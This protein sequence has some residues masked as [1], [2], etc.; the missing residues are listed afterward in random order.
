MSNMKDKIT[1]YQDPCYL[2]FSI[3]DFDV[4]SVLFDKLLIFSQLLY[5]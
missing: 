3:E 1:E 5:L 4:V 2:L